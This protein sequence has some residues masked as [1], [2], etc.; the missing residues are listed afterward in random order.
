[1]RG[2]HPSFLVVGLS[3]LV[4]LPACKLRSDRGGEATLLVS[5]KTAERKLQGTI[6]PEMMKVAMSERLYIGTHDPEAYEF[7]ALDR[8]NKKRVRAE[9]CEQYLKFKGQGAFAYTTADMTTESWFMRASG[10][11][12]FLGRARASKTRDLPD[13]LL[14]RLSVSFMA[15]DEN[16]EKGRAESS[17]RELARMAGV[18]KLK[19][20]SHRIDFEFQYKSITIEEMG[21]GDWNG[22]GLE[23]GLIFVAWHYLEGSG[24]GYS[25]A[26][27]PGG[28]GNLRAYRAEEFKLP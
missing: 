24:R 4:L 7:L 17:I 28:Q 27:I 13:D 2:L 10:A 23:D 18:E 11:L 6:T 26:L 22:D 25:L 16:G 8:D 20:Q 12:K 14:P 1:M 15:G 5:I 9:T 21:R 3:C 19:I